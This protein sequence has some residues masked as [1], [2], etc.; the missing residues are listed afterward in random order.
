MVILRMNPLVDYVTDALPSTSATNKK[1]KVY[2]TVSKELLRIAQRP[3]VAIG[4]PVIGNSQI[5]VII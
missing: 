5:A 4:N 3:I 2:M 1:A